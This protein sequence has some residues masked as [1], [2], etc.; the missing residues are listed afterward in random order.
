MKEALPGL[1]LPSIDNGTA[2]GAGKGGGLT[3]GG[4]CFCGPP[5]L[6]L[7]GTSGD[8]NATPDGEDHPMFKFRAYAEKVQSLP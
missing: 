6:A 7:H 3:S 5:C 8:A 2:G 4:V 1:K